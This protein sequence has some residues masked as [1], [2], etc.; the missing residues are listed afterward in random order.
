MKHHTLVSYA[1]LACILLGGSATFYYV[2][3]ST[4]LQLIVGIITS[5][6]YVFWGIIHHQ[7]QK[8]LH[9]KVVLEYILIGLIAIVLLATVLF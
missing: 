6:A 2:R 7:Q 5:I 9:R 8:D 3:Q 1:V 4:G